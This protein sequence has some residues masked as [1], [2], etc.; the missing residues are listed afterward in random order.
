MDEVQVADEADAGPVQHL[1]GELARAALARPR[2]TRAE[3]LAVV[4]KQP[5]TLSRGIGRPFA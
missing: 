1:A 4:L 3:V 5:L 2:P